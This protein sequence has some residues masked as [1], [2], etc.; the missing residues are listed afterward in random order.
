MNSVSRFFW[1]CA[2]VH[3]DTL[4]KYPEEHNKYVSIGATIFFTGLLQL[5]P[6]DMHYTLFL[7]GI[8]FLLYMRYFSDL[9]G[10]WQSLISTVT[11][12]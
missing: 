1:Y 6:A 8:R 4:I 10:A 12:C 11:S 3:Q 9:F 5:F 7:V 2:G